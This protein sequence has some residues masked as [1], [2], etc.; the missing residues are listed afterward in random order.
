[1][2]ERGE[3]MA[4]LWMVFGRGRPIG[5]RQAHGWSST[6]ARTAQ[7]RAKLKIENLHLNCLRL[8]CN[9]IAFSLC[10]ASEDL[11]K[12]RRIYMLLV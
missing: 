6:F 9:K 10:V 7:P 8:R 1:M 2:I 3:W 5:A 11:K 12:S 4:R